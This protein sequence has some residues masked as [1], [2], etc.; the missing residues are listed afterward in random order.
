MKKNQWIMGLIIFGIIAIV[1]ISIVICSGLKNKHENSS[2]KSEDTIS[3]EGM[4]GESEL[5]Q[6]SVEEDNYDKQQ[7]DISNQTEILKPSNAEDSKTS[8]EADDSNSNDT[9]DDGKQ[10]SNVEGDNVGD[11]T[12]E[13]PFVPFD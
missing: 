9:T 4:E 7:G 13:L 1:S 10:D 12:T 3:E 11:V 8:S 2:T 5:A 6:D